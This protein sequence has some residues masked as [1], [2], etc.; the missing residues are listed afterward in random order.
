MQVRHWQQAGV[1][2]ELLDVLEEVLSFWLQMEYQYERRCQDIYD[3]TAS[4][5]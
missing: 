5:A 1:P 4:A 3:Q 2:E